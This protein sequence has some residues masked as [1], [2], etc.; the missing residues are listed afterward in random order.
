MDTIITTKKTKGCNTISVTSIVRDISTSR[1]TNSSSKGYMKVLFTEKRKML[2][3]VVSVNGIRVCQY[4]YDLS[5]GGTG[6]YPVL[7]DNNV[8]LVIRQAR[9]TIAES[10][11]TADGD[12]WTCRVGSVYP[13][14]LQARKMGVGV[15][16]VLRETEVLEGGYGKPTPMNGVS[17]K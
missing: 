8:E 2:T 3:E 14:V 15:T 9:L 5:A 13:G 16:F 10:L 17:V 7:P 11:G 6:D 1:N 12:E 4:T